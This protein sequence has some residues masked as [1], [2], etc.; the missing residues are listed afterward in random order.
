[1]EIDDL[2]VTRTSLFYIESERYELFAI[3]NVDGDEGAD[4]LHGQ[5]EGLERELSRPVG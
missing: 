3:A 4:P 5:S 1:M 2:P